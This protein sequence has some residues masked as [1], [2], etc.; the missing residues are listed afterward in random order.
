MR[1]EIEEYVGTLPAKRCAL[2]FPDMNTKLLV[3]NGGNCQEGDSQ[4]DLKEAT[5]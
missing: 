3:L 1:P 2:F 4:V 5:R